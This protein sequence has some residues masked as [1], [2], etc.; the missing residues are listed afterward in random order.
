MV[1]V[2]GVMSWSQNSVTWKDTTLDTEV[3][4]QML[5]QMQNGQA[6][7][8]N[9][10]LWSSISVYMRALLYFILTKIQ[11]DGHCPPQFRKG[12]TET[13]VS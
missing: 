3:T 7:Q 12:D 2:C 6:R 5:E 1:N 4:K 9:G 13:E 11:K 10:Y 8:R